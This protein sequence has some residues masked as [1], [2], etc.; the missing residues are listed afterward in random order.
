MSNSR[1]P[2]P[3]SREVHLTPVFWPWRPGPIE[4]ALIEEFLERF[5]YD[6]AAR[7][8]ET[9]LQPMAWLEMPND[10][11]SQKL[12][13]VIY[14]ARTDDPVDDFYERYADLISANK[15]GRPEE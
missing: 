9:L 8:R 5:P 3:P 14:R 13:D 4:A 2:E 7:Y 11:D 6:R 12:L 1:E 15:I 10:P